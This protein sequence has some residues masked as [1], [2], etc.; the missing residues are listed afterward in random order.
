MKEKKAVR[1]DMILRTF[2]QTAV[3]YLC[4]E[5]ITQ[6]DTYQMQA[7]STAI[8]NITGTRPLRML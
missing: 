5:T 2:R 6:P 1:K 8:P 3:T 7:L 4:D